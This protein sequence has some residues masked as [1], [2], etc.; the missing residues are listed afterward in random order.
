MGRLPIL[1]YLTLVHFGISV[2]AWVCAQ[3]EMLFVG[4]PYHTL[5]EITDSTEF[6]YLVRFQ[7]QTGDSVRNVVI[8]DTLDHRFDPAS[9]YTVEASHTYRL[10]HGGGSFVRWYFYDINMPPSGPKSRGW[11][12]FK[13][14]LKPFL[15]PGKVIANRACAVFDDIYSVCTNEAFLWFDGQHSSAEETI[16]TPE[17]PAYTVRPNPN[18]G[19]FELMPTESDQSP[20]KEDTD[21]W[22][23]D[24]QGRRIWQGQVSSQDA[25]RPVLLERPT[26]GLYFLYAQTPK[27]L[28]ITQFTVLR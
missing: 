10:I 14:R 11:V 4:D 16:Q 28:R 25:G 9:L 27:N 23:T 13:V 20:A 18:Y 5:N 7:N 26:P 8:R 12:I 15:S 2:P 17:V 21:C 1:L 22:I 19:S 24:I 6:Y 3:N